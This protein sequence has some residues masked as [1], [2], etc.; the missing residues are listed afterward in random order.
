MRKL[1]AVP[2]L[3]I[4]LVGCAFGNFGIKSE[5]TLLGQAYASIAAMDATLG[6]AVAY[7]ERPRCSDT[8]LVNCAEQSVV[9]VIKEEAPK[10]G[11]ARDAITTGIESADFSGD[12]LLSAVR[13]SQQLLGAFSAYLVSQGVNS[14]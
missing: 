3:L 6:V 13:W 12:R 1:L 5:L 11:L 4:V 8:I 10:L 9:D 14:I 7:V 2:V